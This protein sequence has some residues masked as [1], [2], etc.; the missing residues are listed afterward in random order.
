MNLT[1]VGDC[2][3]PTAKNIGRIIDLKMRFVSKCAENF[4]DDAKN[5]VVEWASGAEMKEVSKSGLW[6]ADTDLDIELKKGRTERLRFVA[7]RWEG[8]VKK[9]ADRIREKAMKEARAFALRFRGKRY[10]SEDLAMKDLAEHLEGIPDT[11]FFHVSTRLYPSM[12]PESVGWWEL[13]L[14]P[15]ISDENI[16]SAAEKEVTI[17]LVTNLDRPVEDGE[18]VPDNYRPASNKEVLDLYNQ[19]YHVERSF[20]FMKSGVGM[21]SVFLQTPSRVNAMMFVISIAVLVSNIADA[22]FKRADTR[23]N[24]RR[25]TMYNLAFEL[26]TTLVTY[27]RS[28]NSLILR[29][30]DEVTEAFFD[31]TDTLLINPQ[32]LLGYAED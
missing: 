14:E 23:S 6:I 5:K 12:T 2:K 24:G 26:Q 1:I 3:L 21:N 13:D 25:L 8:K 30:P 28:E 20:R 10:N 29:G 31:Y 22:M 15:L 27:S 16:R 7:F 32:Y 4:K 17:V 19:E 18:A 9:A 11:Y